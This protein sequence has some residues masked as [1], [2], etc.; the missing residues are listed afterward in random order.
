M[1][2]LKSGWSPKGMSGVLFAFLVLPLGTASAHHRRAAMYD[3]TNPAIVYSQGQNGDGVNGWGTGSD[4][5]DFGGGEHYSN[6]YSG[7]F[8]VHFS[9]TDFQWIGKK[10]P[11]FGIASLF[12]DG[13]SVGT[14]DAYNSTELHQ[15]V[16]YSTSGLANNPHVFQMKI[17]TYPSPA[18]NPASSNWYQ[19]MD[20]F[21]TSGTPLNLPMISPQNGSVTKNGSWSF[22]PN[23]LSGA[24]CWSNDRSTPASLTLP[25]SGTG[26]EVYGHP[27]GE[28]GM[29]DVY[30][31]GSYVTTVDQYNPL[32][33]SV[34][35]DSTND[36][37]L[38]AKAGL[39]AGSHTLRVVVSQSKN[40]SALNYYTQIDGFIVLPAG[41]GGGG[42]GGGG[43]V[44]NGSGLTGQYYDNIDF[45]NLK[46]TR[47]DATVN[48]DW[49]T[50]SPD[51]SIGPD[52]FSVRWTGQV[53]AQFSETYT[54]YTESDDGIRL[55]LNG[56]LVINNWT[57][58]AQTENSGS[59]SLSAGTK[60]D[61]KLEYYQN[62]GLAVAKLL[63]SSP[64]TPKQT[65]PQSQLYPAATGGG[66]G[67]ALSGTSG[68]SSGFNLTSTGTSDWTYWD[69]WGT[70]VRK[71]SGGGQISDASLIGSG[72]NYGGWSASSRSVTWTDG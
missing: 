62:G 64:S 65:V 1:T 27:E 69:G 12:L 36:T 10:G 47:T 54:F 41:G 72:G 35:S 13:N 45:T 22:G 9:G 4:G 53:Q 23:D 7:S 60:A 28:D 16:L 19:V 42:G 43:V 30:I 37:L 61:L 70:L 56:V 17:G 59:F 39:P 48:F 31:D 57:D 40:P 29:M 67:G 34:L 25:F 68:G 20:G 55:W 32:L 51:P 8:V 14:V 6:A 3:D 18:R 24:Y 26:F 52:T 71:A 49:G 5:A 21:T 11:N 66:G 46:V 38:Y 15:Q 33:D 44:G 50:G 2:G 58:H 63:W